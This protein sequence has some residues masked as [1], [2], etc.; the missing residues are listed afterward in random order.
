MSTD[1]DSQNDGQTA[2]RGIHKTRRWVQNVRSKYY[3]ELSATGNCSNS[4]HQLLQTAVLRYWDTLR[5]YR[6]EVEDT[7]EE[8]QLDRIP[9]LA[10]KPVTVQAN[11]PGYGSATRSVQRRA[12]SEVD[13]ENLVEYT[14]RLDSIAHKLGFA[15]EAR[16]QTTRTEIDDEL[17]EE[18]E[19]W[20]KQELEK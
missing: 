18:V 8:N 3:E 12:I 7:W 10:R 9:E 15:A 5:E 2:A 16:K 14:H 6:D 13:A 17:L 1:S 20:R 19:Q 11:A 4:T